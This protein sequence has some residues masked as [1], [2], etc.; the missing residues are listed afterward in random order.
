MSLKVVNPV[1]VITP[2]IGLDSLTKAIESVKEQTYPHIRHLIV[3]DGPE[4][5]E[6]VLSK[7]AIKFNDDTDKKYL[8]ITALPTNTGSNGFYGHRIYAAFP[9][10]VDEPYVAFLDEDNWWEPNHVETLVNTI[11]S[12]NL[13][14]A[15]SLRN[16]FLNEVD[17]GR[18]LDQDCCEAIGRWPI[19]WFSNQKPPE[20]L[21]DT[22]SY[23]FKADFIQRCASIWHHGWGGDRRF[24]MSIMNHSNYRTTGEHTLNYRLPPIQKAYGGDRDIFKKGNAQIKQQYG[25]YPWKKV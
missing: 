14:W 23:M 25:D 13:E 5:F 6:T 21:V 7:I 19:S 12:N 18:F 9:H 2:T 3:V 20:H 4:Y 11:E 10:L 22:S 17:G 1:V 16:V 24:F 8:S 15:H